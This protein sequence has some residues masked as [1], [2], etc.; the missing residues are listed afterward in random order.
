LNETFKGFTADFAQKGFLALALDLFD[1]RTAE[2]EAMHSALR[3]E[4]NS[5]PAKATETISAWCWFI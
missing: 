1:G 3:N 5:N 2:D 4:V